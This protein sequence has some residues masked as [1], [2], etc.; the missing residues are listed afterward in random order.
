[1]NWDVM[2][3]AR[4]TEIA[5]WLW[6]VLLIVWLVLWFGRKPSK[7]LETP[8]E[9]LQHVVPVLAAFLLLFEGNW[10]ILS[11]RVLPDAQWVLLV[12]VLLTFVGVGISIWA[13]LSLGSNWSGMVTLKLDHE[14][15]QKGL[16]R[17]IRHPIYTGILT[18]FIGTAMI[19]GHLRGWLG[20]AIL[21]F[22]F[23][24]KARR[25]ERFLREEFGPGF[26]E[27]VR[28]TGMFLPRMI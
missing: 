26:E 28:R 23:Y 20:F 1:M 3:P 14:L 13:R 24:F 10:R 2:S 5:A 9:R 6:N 21:L 19:Q 16:Y 7:R 17:W 25:E 11:A 8:W 22:S 4:A 18:G 27:H 15:V 12:G